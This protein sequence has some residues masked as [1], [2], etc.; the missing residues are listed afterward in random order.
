MGSEL[1]PA[2]PASKDLQNLLVRVVAIEKSEVNCRD[3]QI[4]F[5][6]LAPVDYDNLSFVN[7]ASDY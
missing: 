3:L 2:R 1:E 5:A 7:I 6:H 4:V